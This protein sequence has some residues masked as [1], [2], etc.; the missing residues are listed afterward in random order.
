MQ[1]RSA[2]IT[3][4]PKYCNIS[5]VGL[6]QAKE[7][8]DACGETS[9]RMTVT[10]FELQRCCFLRL[11]FCFQIGDYHGAGSVTGDVDGGAAHI[12]DTVYTGY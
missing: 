9:C 2:V 6:Q 4:F 10:S 8:Q 3:I 5:S 7:K 1:Q 12:K 11:A